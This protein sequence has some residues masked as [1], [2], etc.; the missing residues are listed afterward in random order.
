M[1][2]PFDACRLVGGA[3]LATVFPGPA[4]GRS[5]ESIRLGEWFRIPGSSLARRPGAVAAQARYPR[6]R[7]GVL[8]DCTLGYKNTTKSC[9]RR[10]LSKRTNFGI[11]NKINAVRFP[12]RGDPGSLASMVI[13]GLSQRRLRRRHHAPLLQRIG[14]PQRDVLAPG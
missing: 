14:D 12:R 8:E 11:P 7:L 6:V 3:I 9:W 1:R 4:A 13:A 10:I 5:P 2:D